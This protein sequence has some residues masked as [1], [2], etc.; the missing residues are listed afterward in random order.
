MVAHEQER[1][2][3]GNACQARN[4]G[5]VLERGE[6]HGARRLLQEAGQQ[7]ERVRTRS[8]ETLAGREDRKKAIRLPFRGPV[9][10]PQNWTREW[11]VYF[12]V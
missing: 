10:V 4:H 6:E 3:V 5:A 1:P 8:E 9:S 2:V 11:M 7:T 12:S